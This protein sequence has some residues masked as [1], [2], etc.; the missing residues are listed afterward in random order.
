MANKKNPNP[1]IIILLKK[2]DASEKLIKQL[3]DQEKMLSQLVELS[4]V[5]N[6][7]I[8]R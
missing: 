4:K 7:E 5:K 3:K 6:D 8:L 1:E 2:I